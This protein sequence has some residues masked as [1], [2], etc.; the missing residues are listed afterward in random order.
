M[1][2]TVKELGF[3]EV[4]LRRIYLPTGFE[5]T[6][7]DP[8]VERLALSIASMG[9]LDPPTVRFSDMRLGP[10]AKRVA[11]LLR[12]QEETCMVRLVECDDYALEL[13]RRAHNSDRTD[14]ETSSPTTSTTDRVRT[15]AELILRLKP[16]LRTF[17]GGRGP[18]AHS[19]AL[20]LLSRE[21]GISEDTLRRRE[22]RE[23]FKK[24]NAL[25]RGP[26]QETQV[27]S[28]VLLGIEVTEL[29]L[30]QAADVQALMDDAR[31]SV[32]LARRVMNKLLTSSQLP[33]HMTKL[34]RILELCQEAESELK[35]QR[36]ACI[37][38]WCK[39]QPG[40]QEKCAACEKTGYGT[41]AQLSGAP[42]K[43]LNGARPLVVVN[44][45]ELR[46]EKYLEET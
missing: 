40:I 28:L 25:K 12:N 46:L 32:A 8:L 19:E 21:T 16:G 7:R 22:S 38:P 42:K 15:T 44:G 34:R 23:R 43:L 14:W 36:P 17:G 9:L 29:F 31:S 3:R 37:C 18:S 11:A 41:E 39:G 20:R 30:S 2:E 10:G 45:E 33:R 27:S 35:E 5:A 1:T 4:E 24:D 26:V 13:M 6:S